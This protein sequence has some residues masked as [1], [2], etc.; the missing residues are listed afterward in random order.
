[1]TTLLEA[2]K[3]AREGVIAALY[4]ETDGAYT[5]LPGVDR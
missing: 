3:L 2:A 5:N 1:M 4:V